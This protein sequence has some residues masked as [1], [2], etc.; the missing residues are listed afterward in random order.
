MYEYTFHTKYQL[1]EAVT[2]RMSLWKGIL[3]L[4]SKFIWEHP[5][6]GVISV[7]LQSHFWGAFKYY[8]L[9]KWPKIWPLLF[10]CL[11]FLDFGW[12]G[13]LE[14]W[15]WWPPPLQKMFKTLIHTPPLPT[16]TTTTTPLVTKTLAKLSYFIDS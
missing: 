4:C 11:H 9:T 7:K 1:L 5:C 10:S 6:W 13:F 8:V 3:K 12:F 16:T 15:F 14:S 2:S